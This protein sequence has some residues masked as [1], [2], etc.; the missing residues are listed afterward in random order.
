[1]NTRWLAFAAAVLWL[2][3]YSGNLPGPER[4]SAEGLNRSRQDTPQRLSPPAAD[5]LKGILAS[6]RLADLRWPNFSVRSEAV[7]AFYSSG[8][9]QLG[10]IRGGKL[11]A[12]ALEL[13]ALLESADQKG[14]SPAD[15]DGPRWK[16]RVDGLGNAPSESS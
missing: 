7:Q 1:M 14:L 6:G 8:D 3:S 13:I 2:V 10:W 11:T 16:A 12:Q 5:E 9:D 15:Y 4:V